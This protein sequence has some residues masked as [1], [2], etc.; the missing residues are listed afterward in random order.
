MVD[1]NE[2]VYARRGL[3][4]RSHIPEL[5]FWVALI[6]IA[7]F[8]LALIVLILAAYASSV[9]GADYF[10]GYGMTF[11]T[12]SWTILFL[13]YILVTPLW[14][15]QF[16]LYWAHLGFEI[17]TVVFWLTAWALLAQEASAWNAF[18]SAEDLENQDIA[19]S[20]VQIDVFP[21]S[22]QAIGAT[23]GAA[24][25]GA[26]TWLLFVIT[27]VVFSFFLHK[28]RAA[29]GATGFCRSAPPADVET[30]PATEEKVPTAA[31]PPVELHHV[32]NGAQHPVSSPA[33]A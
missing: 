18:Q 32:G 7:Q 30:A 28:H 27:L 3:D 6:R 26:L 13:I 5:P 9:F 2:N 12:F 4:G 8:I 15:P 31:Q 24:G 29:N 11:F 16:Y 25:L 14:F 10:A 22:K 23:K 33:V 1:Y 19:D 21:H 20:G 17:T